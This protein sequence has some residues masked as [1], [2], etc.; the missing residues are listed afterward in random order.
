MRRSCAALLSRRCGVGS[1]SGKGSERRVA[2][3]R[4]LRGALRGYRWREL[5]AG[6]A[7]HFFFEVGDACVELGV[8]HVAQL[9]LD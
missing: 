1:R 5:G 3:M 2:V 8:L 6:S 4:R 9:C 7:E